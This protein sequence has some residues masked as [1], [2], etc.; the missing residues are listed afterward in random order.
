M[1]QALEEI[2]IG[3]LRNI[4]REDTDIL[5]VLGIIYV[6]CHSK[7]LTDCLGIT[8][9]GGKYC[10]VKARRGLHQRPPGQTTRTT[11]M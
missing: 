10:G 11:S 2:Y 4:D 5:Q 9:S 3:H 8:M 7:I 1:Y 6:T